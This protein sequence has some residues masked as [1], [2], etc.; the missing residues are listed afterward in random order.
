LRAAIGDTEA[1]LARV[2]AL[3]DSGQ[4]QLALHVVDLLALGA[5]DDPAAVEAKRLKAELCRLGALASSS[6]VTQSLYLNE[7]ESIDRALA[8]GTG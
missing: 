5:G 1:V 6:Y 2:I 4:V 3:R 8:E 7:A